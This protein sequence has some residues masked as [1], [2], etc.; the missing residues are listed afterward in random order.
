MTGRAGAV[1]IEQDGAHRIFDPDG[2]N[3]AVLEK[4]FAFAPRSDLIG[5]KG[6]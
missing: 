3:V 1:R 5:S 6:C 4:D 2:A